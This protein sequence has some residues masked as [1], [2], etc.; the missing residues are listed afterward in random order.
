LAFLRNAAIP[1]QAGKHEAAPPMPPLLHGFQLS[2]EWRVIE[3][4]NPQ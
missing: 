2:L 1:A 4:I 3:R